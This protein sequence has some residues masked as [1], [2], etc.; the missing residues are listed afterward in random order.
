MPVYTRKEIRTHSPKFSSLSYLI[1]LKDQ[2][3]LLFVTLHMFL[4]KYTNLFLA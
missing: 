2:L 3:C 1:L 4:H